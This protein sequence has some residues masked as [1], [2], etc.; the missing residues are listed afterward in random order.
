MPGSD[1]TMPPQKRTG[2]KEIDLNEGFVCANLNWELVG[3]KPKLWDQRVRWRQ[4]AWHQCQGCWDSRG[5]GLEVN[6]NGRMGRNDT[7]RHWDK[8]LGVPQWPNK[9]PWGLKC[10]MPP[11]TMSASELC[12]SPGIGKRGLSPMHRWRDLSRWCIPPR[13]HNP[14]RLPGQLWSQ[15]WS[16]SIG[17]WGERSGHM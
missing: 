11:M 8:D 1:F 13:Q 2:H 12:L 3:C 17:G 16:N 9:C 6:A 10:Q 15:C 4:S 14:S 5:P 7:H